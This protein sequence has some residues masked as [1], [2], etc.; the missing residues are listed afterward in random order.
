M[1]GKLCQS[2]KKV[3]I[4]YRGKGYEKLNVVKRGHHYQA[5]RNKRLLGYT[6][7]NYNKLDKLAEMDRLLQKH[8]LPI[9]RNRISVDSKILKILANWIWQQLKIIY[10][11]QMEFIPG[12]QGWFNIKSV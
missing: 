10:H 12:I 1:N 2:I 4:L 5:Y 8:E 11:D 3:K 6:M 7:N 9:Q